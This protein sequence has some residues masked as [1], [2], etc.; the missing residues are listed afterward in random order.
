MTTSSTRRGRRVDPA[1][2]SEEEEAPRPRR[3]RAAEEESEEETP[4]RRSRRE[5]DTEEDDDDNL[6]AKEPPFDDED[7][8]S[9]R[10]RAR[11]PRRRK[12]RAE[13]VD[14][15][16]EETGDEEPDGEETVIPISRGREKISSSRSDSSKSLYFG[17]LKNGD[18]Q[19]VK[20][21]DVE[22]WAYNQHW[23]KREGKKSFP[24]IGKNC[25]LC[26]VGVESSQKVVYAL[27]NFSGD[28]PKI[29]VFEANMT[30]DD[31]LAGY[32]EDKK[33][34]PLDRLF[35]AISR[36][37]MK[38]AKGRAK[39][40]YHYVPIKE[41]DLEDDWEINADDVLDFL[42]EMSDEDIPSPKDVLGKHTRASLQELVDEV[43]G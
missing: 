25:P 8:D 35:W 20:F 13:E 2:Y 39:Y 10:H 23:V 6:Q 36:S 14:E 21:L 3:R 40:N 38:R 9:P 26:A 7:E 30:Q 18:A 33:T 43:M 28:A 4:R 31:T 11:T 29:Q 1:E 5:R 34:G 37:P 22:P 15:V 19:V 17:F 42:D 16:D 27:V 41:R 24:C 12:A 32:H